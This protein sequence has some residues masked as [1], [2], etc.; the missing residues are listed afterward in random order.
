MGIGAVGHHS[1]GA[2]SHRSPG[3]EPL[4]RILCGGCSAARVC[5]GNFVPGEG[6]SVRVGIETTLLGDHSWNLD[7]PNRSI[8]SAEKGGGGRHIPSIPGRRSRLH[9]R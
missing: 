1:V 6:N 3:G 9:R 8:A 5:L 2:L 7:V 4:N